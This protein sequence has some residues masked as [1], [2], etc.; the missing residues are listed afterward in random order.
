MYVHIKYIHG[1]ITLNLN[2]KVILKTSN[3]FI[4]YKFSKS[5]ESVICSFSNLKDMRKSLILENK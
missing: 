3:D 2:F 5:G 4:H 1:C